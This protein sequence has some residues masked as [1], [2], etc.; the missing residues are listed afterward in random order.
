[1]RIRRGKLIPRDDGKRIEELIGA[2]TTGSRSV[3]VARMLAPPGWSEPAQ[4]PEFDEAVLVER[5]TLTVVTGGRRVRVGPGA[6]VSESVI[7]ADTHVG[8]GARVE[9]AILD[10]Y[11]RVGTGAHVGAEA[12]G[13]IENLDWLAGLTLVGKDTWIPEG[14]VVRRPSSIGV[15]GRYED[16]PGGVLEAGSS[17]FAAE[18]FAS[19]AA[20]VLGRPSILNINTCCPSRNR[21]E[22]VQ[23]RT[24]PAGK[25]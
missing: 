13:P 16:L 4:R 6:V 8:T 20:G 1:M 10:K 14:G 7:M 18:S 25:L 15:G 21:L 3:S 17:D 24:N 19:A 23:Y 22:V 5:G 12:T 9:H 11:V 2:A